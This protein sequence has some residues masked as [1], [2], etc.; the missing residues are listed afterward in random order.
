VALQIRSRSIV[1]P[2]I[3]VCSLA[4]EATASAGPHELGAD[5]SQGIYGGTLVEACGWPSTVAVQAGGS[6]CTG[7]LV[8]PEIVIYA[9][10][11][12]AGNKVIS[13]GESLQSPARKETTEFCQVSPEWQGANRDFAFCK[14]AEP[15]TDIQIV[16]MLMGC[17]TSALTAG[18]DVVLAGFGQADNGPT[19]LKREV[20]TFVGNVSSDEA[21]LGGNG[22]GACHGDSGGPAFI[23]LSSG[24]GGDDTWRVFGVTSRGP[25]G[26]LNGAKYGLMHTAVEWV[27]TQS[28]VDV[29][30]CH[31]A[32][33][34]WNPT[35]DCG[36]FPTA[37]GV[38]HGTWPTC[39]E[40]PVG[41]FSSMCGDPAGGPDDAPPTVDITAPADGSVFESDPGHGT[42]A[43]TISA[44]ADDGDG[45]G[46][47]EVRLVINDEEIANGVDATAPY[48]WPAA[49]P[50]GQYSAYVIA[51]DRAGNE[52]ESAVVHF[53]VDMD[54]PDPSGDEGGEGGTG[55][56]GDGDGLTGGGL[57]GGGSPGGLD[58][59]Q[60]GC[61]CAAA[62]TPR[63]WASL[64]F[65]GLMLW[66]RR[67]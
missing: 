58:E 1:L 30:P 22:V 17:E 15:V 14:L 25:V 10:H 11:C 3:V 21:L 39:G 53:G 13:F 52:A 64:A 65:I 45:W 62:P 60:V 61:G 66:R 40:G 26:C 8:H 50:A 51:V 55:G 5:T 2:L 7:T 28:G 44:S 38:G 19:G 12:G 4:V 42:A 16:P 47:Q 63:A 56:D 36:F 31:D 37:P 32:D 57:T 59:P 49:F 33:G 43:V 27:E 67:R 29:T 23:K 54:A 9:A 24:M 18:A 46:V 35:L 41:G 34:T 48:E 20:A 6:L